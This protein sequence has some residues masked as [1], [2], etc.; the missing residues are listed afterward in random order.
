M[1]HSE[2]IALICEVAAD[3]IGDTEEKPTITA[4]TQLDVEF[5]LNLLTKVE[6]LG[7]LEFRLGIPAADDAQSAYDDICA[8]NVP[9]RVSH[10]ARYLIGQMHD[11][12]EM[13]V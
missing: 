3:E 13:D 1:K 2:V 11:P 9:W 4:D 8:V 10:L 12:V 5:T 7:E 6:I